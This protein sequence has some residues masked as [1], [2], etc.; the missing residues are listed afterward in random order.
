MSNG[1][2]LYQQYKPL[3]FSIAYRMIGSVTEAE[4]IVQETYLTFL[5]LDQQAI[6]DKKAYLCKMAANLCLDTL[7]SARKKRET[8]VG[9]W[10]P[11]PL[12]TK[13]AATPEDKVIE[14]ESLSVSYLFLME[15][16]S[17]AERAVFIFREVFAFNYREIASMVDKTE[18]NCRKI[19]T[20]AKGKIDRH[21][22]PSHLSYEKN[23][24]VIGDFLHAFKNGDTEKVLSLVSEDVILYSDGGG[25]VKAALKPIETRDRVLAFL[26][27]IAAKAPKG[28]QTLPQSIN[29]QP[30][31]IHAIGT[32]I[33]NAVSF[34]VYEQRI[35]QIFIILNPEKLNH[36]SCFAPIS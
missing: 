14:E 16:L 13:A 15:K 31:I 35:K 9:P 22:T 25:V 10:L 21:Q 36:L 3:L 28:L 4:D 19:F 23:Q 26:T 12:I 32:K 27:G 5:Q 1:E 29:G 33:Y 11:E 24:Q 7:K 30:G 34:T 2:I 6:T 8:Y 17:P 20:R 18:A